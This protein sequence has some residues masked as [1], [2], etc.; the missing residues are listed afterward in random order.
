MKRAKKRY[1]WTRDYHACWLCKRKA[2][3]HYSPSDNWK[4]EERYRCGE[5]VPRGCSCQIDSDTGEPARDKK[6]REL[7]CCEWTYLPNGYPFVWQEPPSRRN[8]PTGQIK[9]WYEGEFIDRRQWRGALRR[10]LKDPKD[11]WWP[12]PKKRRRNDLVASRLLKQTYP[13]VLARNSEPER[14][15]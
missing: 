14:V 7:P 4:S 12:H 11:W 13:M 2:L 10:W 3:W 9:R 6:D 15:T 5:C 1:Q 8:R